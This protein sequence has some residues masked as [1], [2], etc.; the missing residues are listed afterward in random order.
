MELGPSTLS[1]PWLHPG[2]DANADVMVGNMPRID[3]LLV[4]VP[5]VRAGNAAVTDDS[6]DALEHILICH[7]DGEDDAL[8][9]EVNA[10]LTLENGRCPG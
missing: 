10:S 6:Q 2:K 3:R 4:G 1:Q 5:I 9:A 8:G 7:S